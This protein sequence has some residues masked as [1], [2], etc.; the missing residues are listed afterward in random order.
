MVEL[1]FTHSDSSYPLVYFPMTREDAYEEMRGGYHW[2]AIE[3][4]IWD[5]NEP[6]FIDR[7][8]INENE[9]VIYYADGTVYRWTITEL[10]D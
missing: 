3:G 4:N 9:A 7:A 6:G 8:D 5:K 10:D 2:Y 1:R